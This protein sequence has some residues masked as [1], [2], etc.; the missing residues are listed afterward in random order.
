M[1]MSFFRPVMV[2]NPLVVKAPKVS[3][4]QPTICK[5][6]GGL[7]LFVIP[8]EHIGAFDADLPIVCDFNGHPGMQGPLCRNGF[9][10]AR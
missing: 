1:M 3:A 9:A 5:R 4:I 10:Q 6:F 2:R 8:H 7:W